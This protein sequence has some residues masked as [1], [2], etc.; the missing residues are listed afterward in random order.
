MV[1]V[2]SELALFNVEVLMAVLAL[3]KPYS[4]NSWLTS[5]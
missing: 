1:R 5:G 2:S 3:L 4:C